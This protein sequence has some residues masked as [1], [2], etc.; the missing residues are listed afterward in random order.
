MKILIRL[1]DNS[2]GARFPIDYNKRVST[3]QFMTDANK[4][5]KQTVEV[6]YTYLLAVRP[7]N[8]F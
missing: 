1:N 2:K 8:S 3:G 5:F 4:H 6:I 7:L